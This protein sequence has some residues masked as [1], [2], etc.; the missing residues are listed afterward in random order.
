MLILS[1]VAFFAVVFLLCAI[2]VTL[3]WMGF[4]KT[5]AEEK[6]AALRDREDADAGDAGGIIRDQRL[7]TLNF[8]D[9]L[10]A[11]FDFIE[12]LKTRIAQAE[13]DWSVGRV[14]LSMLLCG[15]IALAIFLNFIA[16][17][18][19]LPCA[20]LAALIPYALILRKRNKRFLKFRENFPDGLGAA[21]V[22][23]AQG[24]HGEQHASKRRE[25]AAMRGR[26]RQV[27]NPT[28]FIRLRASNAQQPAQRRGF[29]A[30]QIIF[31]SAGEISVIAIGIFR[32]QLGRQRARGFD[33]RERGQIAFFNQCGVIRVQA[34]P[35]QVREL[36]V[37]VARIALQGPIRELFCSRQRSVELLL[38]I[39]IRIG[40][41]PV[42]KLIIVKK[43]L[44][45]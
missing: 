39:L 29:L 11:R 44:R 42:H 25:I 33:L 7:S 8:W 12:I 14:T 21:H 6:E 20:L 4:M 38:H 30:Q 34:E 15:T 19:A 17:W 35:H 32:K 28:I 13:L 37:G 18:V 26:E 23:V 24:R 3:A 45:L 27:V 31:D 2:A 10:L 43:E 16:W 5:T 22:A 36:R 1:I 41:G 40:L 9:S